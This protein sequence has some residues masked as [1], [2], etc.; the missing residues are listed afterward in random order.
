MSYLINGTT[1]YLI[2][3]S[4]PVSAVPLTMACWFRGNSTLTGALMS[5]STN[6][7][8]A[9]YSLVAAGTIAGDPIQAGS[10]N[11]GGTGA[12]GVTSTGFSS[13]V[14][15]HACGV[16][17]ST[18][19]RSA[20]LNGGGKGTDTTSITASADRTLLGARISTTV[21]AFF[22]GDLAETAIW[23]VALSDQEVA[24]LAKGFSPSLIRP[25]SLIFYAPLIRD[26]VD[27]QRGLTLT[28]TAGG[29]VAQQN[30]AIYGR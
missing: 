27:Y 30:V 16:Y 1:Q 17:A 20:Y 9:R 12:N 19:S 10:T 21:G 28:N 3:S 11:S 5:L 23:N 6:G 8:V 25:Q 2:G 7:G 13:G 15:N 22:T 29:T 18:T 24:G 4:A 26:C 14:W